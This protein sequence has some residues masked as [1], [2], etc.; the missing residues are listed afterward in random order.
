M[1]QSFF[2]Y[3]LENGHCIQYHRMPSGTCYHAET[4]D[5]VQ[6]LLEALRSKSQLVRLFYGNQVTGQSWFEEHDVIGHIGRSTGSIKVPLLVPTGECG[7]PALLDQC[8]IRIDTP[9]KTLYQHPSFRVGEFKL[10]RGNQKA[11]PWEVWIDQVLQARFQA[12]SEALRYSAF[13]QGQ[14]FSLA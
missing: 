8:I 13:L 12:K 7:G 14:R 3:P 9:R 1:H 4:P 5:A 6:V 10:E 2:E 11:L